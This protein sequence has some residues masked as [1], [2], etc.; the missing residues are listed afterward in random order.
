VAR[1]SRIAGVKPAQKKPS[2]SG[3]EEHQQAGGSSSPTGN[4]AKRDGGCGS[5]C[6]PVASDQVGGC[7]QKT[8]GGVK[9]KRLQAFTA[10]LKKRQARIDKKCCQVG[11]GQGGAQQVAA[12][13]VARLASASKGPA[14]AAAKAKKVAKKKPQSKALA[15]LSQNQRAAFARS[16][17]IK[18][19]VGKKG[20]RAGQVSPAW[21]AKREKRMAKRL[22]KVAVMNAQ[23]KKAFAVADSKSRARGRANLIK[24]APV[25][26]ASTLGQKPKG[27]T[28]ATPPERARVNT[29]MLRQLKTLRALAN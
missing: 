2:G 18:K 7:P 16:W 3:H 5:Q 6:G 1:R 29:K 12:K 13:R 10:K 23:Q 19:A 4:E 26:R 11:E 25:S 27:Q 17:G 24:S 14:L 21:I 15:K 20:V 22:A 9:E 8:A 28:A